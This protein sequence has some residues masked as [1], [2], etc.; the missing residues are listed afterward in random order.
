MTTGL[1]RHISCCCGLQGRAIEESFF[2]ENGKVFL[3]L[4]KWNKSYAIQHVCLSLKF[5]Q[6]SPQFDCCCS[7]A[8]GSLH[9]CALFFI[10]GRCR[11]MITTVPIARPAIRV[12]SSHHQMLVLFG[13][14]GDCLASLCRIGTPMSGR[15]WNTY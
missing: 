5:T 14:C 13:G 2:A 9:V 11:F 1:C 7:P 8:F 15:A 4:F 10:R 3:C 6:N 12:T